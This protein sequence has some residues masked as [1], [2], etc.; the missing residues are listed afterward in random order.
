MKDVVD[1]QADD[2]AAGL[3]IEQDDDRGDATPQRQA[4]I[5][6]ESA[7]EAQALVLGERGCPPGLRGWQPEASGEFGALA[8]QQ[9]GPDGV[10]VVLVVLDMPAVDVGLAACGEGQVLIA[11]PD[12][13]G[14]RVL[15]LARGVLLA[16]G[17]EGSAV[18]AG[19]EFRQD[20]PGREPADDLGVF[21]LGDDGKVTDEPALEEADLLVD[22]GPAR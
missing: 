8:P 18:G 10:P 20:A 9:E 5:G 12:Q 16:T 19:P 1:G 4:V 22:T 7:K 6:E 11:E 2:S 14:R 3:R 17:C 21:R 13:E 15:D